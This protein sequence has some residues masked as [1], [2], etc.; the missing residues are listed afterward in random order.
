[1]TDLSNAFKLIQNNLDEFSKNYQTG[2]DSRRIFHGRG[3]T[4]Q[5]LDWCSIDS[6]EGFIVVTFFKAPTEEFTSNL[7]ESFGFEYELKKQL[8]TYAQALKLDAIMVQRRYQP[9]APIELWM[10]DFPHVAYALRSGLRFLLSFKQQNL[11]FFLDIEPA[12]AWLEENVQR[13]RVLNLF[14]Y[15]CT[16]SVVANAAGADSVVNI[17][18]SK[19]S[20]SVGRENHTINGLDIKKNTFLGHD[21]LKS[22]GKLKKLGP[23]DIVIIDPPS[24]Q[25]G[26]FIASKDYKK[27]LT[28]MNSLVAEGGYFLACLNAPEVSCTEFRYEIAEH[29]PEF[30]CEKVLDPSSDFPDIDIHHALKMVVYRRS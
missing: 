29:C 23:Y 8:L 4:Y 21:I 20:L 26:S 14:S 24:F 12:R 28:K 10:G 13:K 16:F 27:V 25:K 19:R 1:M 7:S 9:M 5:H 11:G 18:L 22:W 30:V 6:F 2:Q 3:K 17:D 15:T